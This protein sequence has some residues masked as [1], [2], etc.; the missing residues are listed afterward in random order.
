MGGTTIKVCDSGTIL[1]VGSVKTSFCG[2]SSSCGLHSELERTF[3]ESMDRLSGPIFVG[4]IGDEDLLDTGESL[5]GVSSTMP[6]SCEPVTPFC[7]SLAS[8]N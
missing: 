6:S 3:C 8:F 4:S 2:M 1:L 7:G 5:L